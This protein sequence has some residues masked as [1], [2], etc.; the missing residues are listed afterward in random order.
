MGASQ[1]KKEEL[2][3]MIFANK[4]RF[5]VLKAVMQFSCIISFFLNL[6]AKKYRPS[7][8]ISVKLGI[9]TLEKPWKMIKTSFHCIYMY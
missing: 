5:K 6:H 7:N 9:E 3:H 2:E 8:G 4:P 1:S